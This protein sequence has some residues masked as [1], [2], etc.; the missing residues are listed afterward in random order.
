MYNLNAFNN[1][2]KAAIW[3][4]K[5]ESQLENLFNTIEMVF[6]I[7]LH[8]RSLISMLSDWVSFLAHPNIFGIKGCVVVVCCRCCIEMVCMLLMEVTIIYQEKESISGSFVSSSVT[9][10]YENAFLT[11]FH[12]FVDFINREM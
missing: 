3:N 5:K 1:I 11:V 12:L 7:F 4:V 6:M 9:F 8:L 2:L 10:F